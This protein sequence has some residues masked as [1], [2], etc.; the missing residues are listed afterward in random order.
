MKSKPAVI[1]LLMM[2]TV[3]AAGHEIIISQGENSP[4][5][6]YKAQ[7][8][9]LAI[10]VELPGTIKNEDAVSR[11]YVIKVKPADEYD[12]EPLFKSMSAQVN[13]E[14]IRQ[15]VYYLSDDPLPRRVLNY[16]LPGHSLSTLEEADLWI[17]QKLN[18]WGYQPQRDETQV[19]AFGRDFSKPAAHQYAPPPEGA[20]YF[21]AHNI[22]AEKRG[23]ANPGSIIAVI[24]HK[25]SQ[26]WI[27]SPGANDNAIGTCTALELARV[28][29]DYKPRHTLMFIFCNEEHTPWTSITAAKN[30]KEAG[31]DVLALINLD[32][33]GGKSEDKSGRLINVTRFTTPEG[34]R[35][36]DLNIRLNDRFSIGLEQSK[37]L[38][39]NPGDDDGSFIK[40]G[41]PWAVLNIGSMPYSDPNYHLETDTPEK[42]DYDTAE[43]VV[44]LTLALILHLD[45]NG[46]P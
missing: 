3:F 43:K 7:T 38:S 45:H 14:S 29:K 10:S 11:S 9:G 2:I 31:L 8:K 23:T 1:L 28:M 6:S 18:E 22:I 15:G 32:A 30:I 20:P 21:T 13:K 16:S 39:E 17:E 4:F 24:A 12:Y 41:F 35:L 40:A 36:A 26:S 34:E 19:R 5:A 33:V 44:S 25:D 46:R 27:A 42:V 37:Y